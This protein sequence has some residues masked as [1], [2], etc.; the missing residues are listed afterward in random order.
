M[1]AALASSHGKLA[2]YLANRRAQIDEYREIWAENY[3]ELEVSDTAHNAGIR[4]VAD[5]G[6]RGLATMEQIDLGSE[7]QSGP[8]FLQQDV[9]AWP[10]TV[11]PS[12]QVPEEELLP[13]HRQV[14]ALSVSRQH[15]FLDTVKD[16]FEYSNKYF[17]CLRILARILRASKSAAKV[18][19][20][21]SKDTHREE[22]LE[23]MRAPLSG[24]DI[25]CAKKIA[26]LAG[27]EKTGKCMGTFFSVPLLH[28]STHIGDSKVA[29]Y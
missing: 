6:T 21:W 13:R 9:Q 19:G 2:P 25:E 22:I 16:V 15:S 8:T 10:L 24:Q 26:L 29:Q 3:P 14:A 28:A 23:S 20:G 5:L 12:L 17:K 11:P 18:P 7:W 4:N 1:S 27:V